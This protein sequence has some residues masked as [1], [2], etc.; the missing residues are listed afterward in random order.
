[1]P[2]DPNATCQGQT[3]YPEI[4]DYL[5]RLRPGGPWLLTAIHPVTNG[6]VTETVRNAIEIRC[7]VE[8][9]EG[10]SN[11]YFGVNPTR[12]K[13]SKKPAKTDLAAIE[14]LFGDL[15]PKSTESPKDAKARYL[16]ALKS[17]PLTPT[18][19]IDS[20]GGI[21]C[22]WRLREPIQLAEPTWATDENGERKPEFP[23]KTKAVIEDVEARTKAL[24]ESLGSVAGTQNIDRLLRCPA[25]PTCQTRKNAK[26][27]GWLVRPRCSALT[28]QRTRWTVSR[29]R[30][31]TQ[32]PRHR[33]S[34]TT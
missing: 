29:H 5:E 15:D 1:M 33:R 32:Q 11:L 27:G 18:A 25:P 34:R 10:R 9:H 14:Y 22:L 20:G 26:A 3:P 6:I 23:D 16:A 19:T 12:R 4:E 21:Q 7:F 31:S 30:Q 13:V 24:M 17:Y 28:A 8:T 2:L